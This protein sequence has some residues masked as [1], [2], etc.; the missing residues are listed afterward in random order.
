MDD[1]G[2]L[3]QSVI[4]TVPLRVPVAD[5][6]DFAPDHD[7]PMAKPLPSLGQLLD[8]WSSFLDG[9]LPRGFGL[10]GAAVMIVASLVYGVIK[11]E[12]VPAIVGSIKEARD[13]VANA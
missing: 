11:G 5:H 7:A 8:R 10:A 13:R 4:G 1:G 9:R 2:R 3:A 6:L 12:H